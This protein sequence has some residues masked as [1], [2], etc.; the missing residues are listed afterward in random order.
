M[1]K[2][3]KWQNKKAENEICIC[4]STPFLGKWWGIEIGHMTYVCVYIYIYTGV[5]W[6]WPSILLLIFINN[7]LNFVSRWSA[8]IFSI[9]VLIWDVYYDNLCR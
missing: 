5:L 2:N 6:I 7:L 9:S 8:L 1:E 4:Q 3:C